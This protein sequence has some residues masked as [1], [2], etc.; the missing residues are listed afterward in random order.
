L[1][2]GL[3]HPSASPDLNA[4]RAN[5]TKKEKFITKLLLRKI[6]L[7]ASYKPQKACAHHTLLLEIIDETT[8]NRQQKNLA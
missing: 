1:S 2:Y 8:R 4:L 7:M 6:A 5:I 3:V